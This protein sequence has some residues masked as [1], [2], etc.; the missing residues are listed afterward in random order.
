M[1]QVQIRFLEA[2]WR[3]FGG[4]ERPPQFARKFV[5]WANHVCLFAKYDPKTYADV[6]LVPI[7]NIEEGK[8]ATLGLN[9]IYYPFGDRGM[10]VESSGDEFS[11]SKKAKLLRRLKRGKTGYVRRINIPLF[12]DFSARML[13]ESRPR[14]KPLPM[15]PLETTVSVESEEIFS[16]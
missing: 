10:I 7:C 9:T 14:I 6:H 13:Y 12:V 2:S 15:I 5:E 11:S 8:F 16:E 1:Y 3:E 4:D